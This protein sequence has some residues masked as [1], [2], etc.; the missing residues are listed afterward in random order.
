MTLNNTLY[1]YIRNLQ[2]DV[3][4][5]TDR[6]GNVVVQYSY[7]SWGNTISTTG[8]MAATLGAK[9]PFRYRGYYYD[10]ETGMY[11]LQRRYYDPELR[12]FIS[13]DDFNVLCLDQ[14]SFANFN[15]YNYCLNSPITLSDD[16]GYFSI[17][18]WAKVVVGVGTIAGLA[19]ATALTGGAGGVVLAAALCGSVVGGTIGV[20]VGAMTNG[21]DGA[22]NGFAYGTVAGGLIGGGLAGGNIASGTLKIIGTAQKTHT[23]G[24]SFFQNFSLAEWLLK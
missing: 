16:T 2:G 4:G 24:H 8:S 18:N 9:N 6:N 23:I 5:I 14:N 3:I 11:Y 7:D 17:P 22:A 13:A 15:L 12:K 19:V 21:V 1:L 10:A 20:G